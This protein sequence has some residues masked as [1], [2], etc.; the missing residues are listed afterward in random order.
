MSEELPPEL[1]TVDALRIWCT[2]LNMCGIKP[3]G[4]RRSELSGRQRCSAVRKKKVLQ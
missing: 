3:V 1:L 4:K 2:E